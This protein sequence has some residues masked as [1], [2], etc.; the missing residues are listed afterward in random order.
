VRE[1]WRNPRFGRLGLLAEATVAGH[2]LVGGETRDP[3]TTP[4][5]CEL[6]GEVGGRAEVHLVRRLAMAGSVRHPGV[7][8]L[9][10]EL[11]DGAESG[12]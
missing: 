5:R 2:R 4:S 10:V 9:D 1:S 8:L 11:H 3:C 6:G 12:K 7:V